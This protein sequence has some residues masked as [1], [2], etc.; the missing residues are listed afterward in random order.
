MQVALDTFNQELL[1]STGLVLVDFSAPWCGLCRFIQPI[2]ERL[3]AE[4]E[5]AVKVVRVNVDEN[6]LLSRRY[7]VQSLP[8]LILFEKGQEVQRLEHFA[9]RDEVLRRC[10]QLFLTHLPC[11]SQG[12]R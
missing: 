2:T 8:T 3:A 9:S 7:R 5:G 4:W 11:L 10:E 6:F 12:S 1:T